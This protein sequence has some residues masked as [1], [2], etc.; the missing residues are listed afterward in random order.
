MF[1]YFECFCRVAKGKD[2]VMEIGA[3]AM[4]DMDKLSKWLSNSRI[5]PNDPANSEL[6]YLLRVCIQCVT[7]YIYSILCIIYTLY[8]VLYILYTLYYIYYA[9]YYIYSLLSI[10]YTLYSVLYTILCIIYTL[11]SV[12]Y[13]L[14]IIYTIYSLLY[15]LYTLYYIYSMLR[16]LLQPKGGGDKISAPDYF[17]LEQLQEEFNFSTDEEL[18]NDKRLQI[19]ELREKEVMEFR[20]MKMV[21]AFS[22]E[23]SPD[24]FK[25]L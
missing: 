24:I 1:T 7:Y 19:L 16:P 6:V 20:N 21:P 11:H 3:S 22:H 18:A 12:Y 4:M 2:A 8:S 23:L 5:D 17:R 14:C 10:I 15:I 9:L 13:I 25:V